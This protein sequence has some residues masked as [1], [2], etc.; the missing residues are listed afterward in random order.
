VLL[1]SRFSSDENIA[2]LSRWTHGSVQRG[3]T[4]FGLAD[5][6]RNFFQVL[7]ANPPRSTVRAAPVSMFSSYNSPGGGVSVNDLPILNVD[8]VRSW[9]SSCGFAALPLCEKLAIANNPSTHAASTAIKALDDMGSQIGTESSSLLTGKH[10]RM[11]A[12]TASVRFEYADVSS[13]ANNLSRPGGASTKKV[14]RSSSQQP[15]RLQ[16]PAQRSNKP[17]QPTMH[18]FMILEK[19]INATSSSSSTADLSVKP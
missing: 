2:Q 5:E 14:R 8:P 18:H 6:L 13:S 11:P 12:R 10:G 16:G 15:E 4:L 3:M 1:D 9:V 19:S 17:L 7:A